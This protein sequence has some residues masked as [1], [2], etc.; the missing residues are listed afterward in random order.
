MRM[1]FY[2]FYFFFVLTCLHFYQKKNDFYF[3]R[4]KTKADCKK[5]YIES[6]NVKF[7]TISN[8]FKQRC[9]KHLPVVTAFTSRVENNKTN[10]KYS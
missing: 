1:I 8:I 9:D 10:S 4:R 7:H 6:E 3:L 5:G 2:V